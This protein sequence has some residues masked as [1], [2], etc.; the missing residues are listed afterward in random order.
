MLVDF[1]Y[2]FQTAA[3]W[4][5]TLPEGGEASWSDLAGDCY[6][7]GVGLSYK[8][9]ERLQLSAGTVFTKFLFKDKEAYYE[10]LG[11]FEAPKGDNWNSGI[12]LAYKA[13]SRLTVNLALGATLWKNEEIGRLVILPQTIQVKASSY[14]LSIGANINL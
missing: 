12:G 11:E 3:N 2:Y 14:S 9:S 8:L 6:A 7:A 4:S 5:F 13:C 1:N 10:R